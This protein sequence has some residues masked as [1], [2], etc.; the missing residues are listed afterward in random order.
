MTDDLI[1]LHNKSFKIRERMYFSNQRKRPL[2][3]RLPSTY[4]RN[5]EN[6]FNWRKLEEEKHIRDLG[7][8]ERIIVK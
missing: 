7:I 8:D 3:N 1:K 6:N 5:K 4:K 2:M